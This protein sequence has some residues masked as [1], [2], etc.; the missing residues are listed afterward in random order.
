[1]KITDLYEHCARHAYASI[2]ATLRLT[3]LVKRR[4]NDEL[5]V[6][7]TEHVP[8]PESA[9]VTRS[10][11]GGTFNNAAQKEKQV[12]DTLR[13]LMPCLQHQRSLG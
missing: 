1:V 5:A 11:E 6:K 4:R 13:S 9:A 7:I 3:R 12:D 8:L 10:H 2:L